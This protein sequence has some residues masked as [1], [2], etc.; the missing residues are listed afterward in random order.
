MLKDGQAVGAVVSFYDIT[1][2]KRNE[3]ALL[4]AK[5]AAEAANRV[6]SEFLANMSHEIRTPMH[7]IIGMSDLALAGELKEMSSEYIGIVRSSAESLLSIVNNI[8]DLAKVESGEIQLD[9]TEF[10]LRA[11]VE[12]RRTF[13]AP[14]RQKGLKLSVE[15][16]RDVA[17]DVVGDP[18]RLRQIVC[19]LIG[20]AIRFTAEG[21]VRLSIGQARG[22]AN[23]VDLHFVVTDAGPGVPESQRER[24]FEPF[25]Q[26]DGSMTRRFGGTGLGLS[27]SAKLVRLM[28]GR[29]W[30][31]PRPDAWPG[32]AF[33][34]TVTLRPAGH[35]LGAL[36]SAVTPGDRGAIPGPSRPLRV[37]VAEDNPV[38][39]KILAA[40]LVKEG[41]AV[42]LAQNGRE[43]ADYYRAETFDLILMDVQ[44]PVMSGLDA[45]R[46]IRS[47]KTSVHVP[48]VA[49]TAHAMRGDREMCMAAGRDDYLTKPIGV[50]EL[51]RLLGQIAAGRV[52]RPGDSRAGG[53]TV[54][55]V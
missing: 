23:T 43:A 22:A 53:S 36:L 32:A 7:G 9:E 3:E 11:A 27:I 55:R 44:M 38:N 19:N 42:V 8:L 41:H 13:E 10:N 15:V 4:R 40:L 49:L 45:A 14:A 48:I 50:A 12:I 47:V 21:E 20:N 30:T 26:A 51:R 37:L 35:G 31:E 33:H 52:Q 17:A 29:I 28:G 16:G 5:Q 18:A 6:K 25:V 1:K 54:I 46:E 39:Q 24:I 34:F 2:R